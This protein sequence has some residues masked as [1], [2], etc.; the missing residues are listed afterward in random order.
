M[1]YI[2]FFLFAFGSHSGLYSQNLS[3]QTVDHDS[4]HAHVQSMKSYNGGV[5]FSTVNDAFPKS[6]LNYVDS[7]Q[8]KHVL[9]ES[10]FD[11]T[12]VKYLPRE[13]GTITMYMVGLFDYD[14]AVGAILKFDFDGE[15]V[16]TEEIRYWED[17]NYLTDIAET[18]NPEHVLVVLND[19]LI[20][21]NLTTGEELD[22][23]E[24]R[25]FQK[26]INTST[27]KCFVANQN[28]VYKHEVDATFNLVF[29]APFIHHINAVSDS[30]F[31]VTY[32]DSVFIYTDQFEI[33]LAQFHIPQGY[34][35][36]S[37]VKEKDGSFYVELQTE[38]K[39]YSTWK[40]NDN[41]G[42]DQ[43][44]IE[45]DGTG[46]FHVDILGTEIVTGGTFRSVKP[47]GL[48]RSFPEQSS[49]EY[50]LIDISLD[51][52]TITHIG[53]D[54]SYTNISLEGDTIYSFLYYFDIEYTVTN[55]GLSPIDHFDLYSSD[56]AH[57]KQFFHSEQTETIAVGETK[58]FLF[59]TTFY[60]Y[61]QD[62]SL[63]DLTF[64]IPGA[65]H[66]MDAHFE[67]NFIESSIIS[68]TKQINIEKTIALFPNPCGD[69]VSVIKPFSAYY[70]YDI[71]GKLFASDQ[72]LFQHINISHLGAGIYFVLLQDETSSYVQKLVKL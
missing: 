34:S 1:K 44:R 60:S 3:F 24:S 22:V 25:V 11:H 7:N 59:P 8:I 66:L 41:D 36:V 29:D 35:Q 9:H 62:L 4:R 57:P 55:Q 61:A 50:N 10:Y 32:A 71:T 46:I 37:E 28:Q 16:T 33:K 18:E 23:D 58:E 54:T 13:D 40:S 52:L 49:P 21:L 68:S 17:Y 12:T 69:L 39:E 51:N 5:L 38:S 47:T 15:N 30:I 42:F 27:G 19:D 26:L 67:D 2:Y 6:R 48:V 72:Q 63:I 14:L 53:Q 64:Y 65:N 70:I 20:H 56:A 43:I 45:E 31:A